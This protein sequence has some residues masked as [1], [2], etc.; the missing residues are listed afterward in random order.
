MKLGRCGQPSIG[1][2]SQPPGVIGG[3]TG[4]DE[5]V[6]GESRDDCSIGFIAFPP[7]RRANGDPGRI[8]VSGVGIRVG[9]RVASLRCPILRADESDHPP[10]RRF[11]QGVRSPRKGE[12]IQRLS[13][14]I[15]DR[16]NVGGMIP[17]RAREP[18]GVGRRPL[19]GEPQVLCTFQLDTRSFDR[20]VSGTPCASGAGP[21]LDRPQALI[22][23]G[24]WRGIP[25]D[26]DAARPRRR[27]R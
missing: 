5:V 2:G 26:P 20:F 27:N 15:P 4:Q 17:R 24:D 13:T 8:P 12:A 3:R 7:Y 10:H 23:M 18:H 25:R 16:R 22:L 14:V 19:A 21:I 11:V 6:I 9:A 1:V